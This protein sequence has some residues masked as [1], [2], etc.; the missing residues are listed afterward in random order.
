MPGEAKQRLYEL[1]EERFGSKRALRAQWAARPDD[2]EDILRAGARRARS[3]AQELMAEV[4]DAC[5]LVRAE[6]L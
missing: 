2:V 4:R 6:S 3:V 5:G 1:Y